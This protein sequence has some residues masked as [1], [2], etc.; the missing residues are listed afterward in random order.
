MTASSV[1]SIINSATV[2]IEIIKP[3]NAVVLW[4][5]CFLS[6]TAPNTKPVTDNTALPK[7][8]NSPKNEI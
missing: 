6:D 3:V 1:H 2:T 7:E 4:F 8:K 5:F